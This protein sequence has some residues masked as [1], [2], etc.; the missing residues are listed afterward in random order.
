MQHVLHVLLLL[1]QTITCQSADA[2]RWVNANRPTWPLAQVG[3]WSAPGA[4]VTRALP[5]AR[6]R[7]ASC[8]DVVLQL[9]SIPSRH[10]ASIERRDER[11]APRRFARAHAARVTHGEAGVQRAD[12]GIEASRGHGT[13]RSV[14]G[15]VGPEARKREIAPP[16]VGPRR[17][18]WPRGEGEWTDSARMV[19]RGATRLVNIGTR[20]PG[21]RFYG[22][23]VHLSTPRY[24]LA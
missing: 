23:R 19:R 5:R 13:G 4:G 1:P 6:H 17:R 2:A 7:P 15:S 20:L 9:L 8:T 10:A 22:D 21:R 11:D 16:M 12:G 24:Y 3:R 14:W 18:A